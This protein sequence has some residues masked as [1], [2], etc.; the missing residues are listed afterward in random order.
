L[1]ADWVTASLEVE[2]ETE[3]VV[4]VEAEVASEASAPSL[5]EAVWERTRLSRV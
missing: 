2:A 1:L 5:Q 3:A 4:E